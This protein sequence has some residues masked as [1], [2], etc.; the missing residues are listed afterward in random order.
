MS[1]FVPAYRQAGVATLA[2]CLPVERASALDR[3]IQS[4]YSLNIERASF[5]FSSKIN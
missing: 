4:W 5:I 2:T 1:G 3:K